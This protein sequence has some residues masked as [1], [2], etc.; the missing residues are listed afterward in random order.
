LLGK[1]GYVVVVVV[2][3]GFKYRHA[4]LW[5]SRNK[6]LLENCARSRSF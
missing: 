2:V 4:S 6:N 3:V 1:K 5:A